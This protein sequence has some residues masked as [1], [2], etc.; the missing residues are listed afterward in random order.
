M[1]RFSFGVFGTCFS[2]VEILVPKKVTRPKS[3]GSKS[4]I[5]LKKYCSIILNDKKPLRRDDAI[6]LYGLVRYMIDDHIAH[7]KLS[8]LDEK[9]WTLMRIRNNLDP[10]AQ[11]EA[12]GKMRARSK[13]A[14]EMETIDAVFNRSR[15]FRAIFSDE[16]ICVNISKIYGDD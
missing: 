16:E 7:Y 14:R 4:T 8:D 12:F 3:D 15:S 11:Y 1:A 5:T 6:E 9:Y 2:V 13:L 10:H